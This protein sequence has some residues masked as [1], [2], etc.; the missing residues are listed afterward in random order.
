M[1]GTLVP[2]EGSRHVT[3]LKRVKR[4]WHCPLPLLLFGPCSVFTEDQSAV[5][6]QQ[7]DWNVPTN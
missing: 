7:T 2:A 4:A 6:R 3:K 1:H 5:S